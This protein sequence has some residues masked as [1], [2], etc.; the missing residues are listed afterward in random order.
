M[1]AHRNFLPPTL[2]SKDESR[3]PSPS[4]FHLS[5][6]G[7]TTRRI[8]TDTSSGYVAP[9]FEGKEQQMEA[10]IGTIEASGFIPAAFI[11]D[12]VEWFYTKLGIDDMYF[13][14]ESVETIANHILAL[15][16]GKVAAF[17]RA[18]KRLEIRLDRE[19]TDHAV[20]IDTSRPGVS[21]EE[22]PRYETRIDEK[23]LNDSHPGK[24]YRV[25][26]FRSVE[27]L[28]GDSN[29]QLRCYF[30]YQ[31]Q[32]EE[33]QPNENETDIT[34]I[35][36]K[37]F[38]EKASENTKQLYGDIVQAVVERTGPVIEMFEVQ[39]TR[40]KRLIIGYRQRSAKGLFSAMSDLY[41]YYGVTSARKY[42]EQFSN[43]V[44]VMSL[45]LMPTGSG[46]AAKHPPI[47]ASIHQIMK[48]V[49]LLYCI[50]QNNF[51]KH[52]IRGDLSLQETIYAHCVSIFITHFL[53]RL[54]NEYSSL[55]SLLDSNNTAHIEVL[56][57][58]KR[59]LRQETFT[60]EY[61]TEII[62]E[63]P[64]LVRPLYLQ[65]A[66][67]HYVQTRGETDDF[68]PTLS[69]QRLRQD[70]VLK[71]EEIV[72]HIR[73]TV[74]NDHQATVMESFQLFNQHVLK[75]N[76]YTPTKVAL[77]FRFNPAFLPSIEYPQPLYG[78]FLVIGSEF[79]GFHLR[80]RDIA[81]GGIRIVKSRNREAYAINVRSM[82]DENYNL[83]N[84]QQRKNKDIPEGGSKGVVLL[85]YNSQDKATQ[86]FQKYIDSVL[87][88]LL[89]PT[90][91]GIKDPIVDLHG[92]PEILFMGPDENTASLVNWATEHARIRGAPWWKSFFTGKSPRL[93]GI[94]HDEYGMTSLSVREYVLGIYRKLKIDPSLVRKMQTGGPDGDLGSNEILLSNE[95][96]VAIVD[97]SGVLVDPNGLDRDELI[98]LAKKRVMISEF[99]ITKLSKQGYRVLVDESKIKLPSGE[100]V[101]NGTIFRNTFHLKDI[102]VDIFTPCG[103]RPEAIESGNVGQ[104]IDED[105]KSKIPYIVEGANLF[106][107]QDAKIRLEKAGAILFKDAS[108]NK[109]GVTS[110]SLEVLAS[111][112]FDDAGFVENMCVKEDGSR[113]EF[114]G[115]YVKEVQNIIKNNARLEFEAIWA[116]HERT[117][118]PRSLISDD[119][120]YA[121]TNLDEELQKTSL[122]ADV[123]LRKNVLGAALPGLLVKKLGLE[124][125][126]KRVPEGYL[127]AIF[128]SY[129]ASRFV[130]RCGPSASPL[131]FYSFM[132]TLTKNIHENG[133]SALNGI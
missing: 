101:P 113:P 88:L 52:F 57:K 110:S 38:L 127:K 92:K 114:Y 46:P 126:V 29:A 119:L 99:D 56:T 82:F 65:F 20:Y 90:S 100:Y 71:P 87:D 55:L 102:G 40:E 124:T 6:P 42:V 41:H 91:P 70:P 85:D 117:G 112:S 58:I 28:G 32:F 78:M 94:P 47:E 98:R 105:G 128:G 48:E 12:E 77:S 49:S 54:G 50:P 131:A 69:Y 35:A 96:Y 24:A 21:V 80:F 44:T 132:T 86:A 66:N 84:T 83:A 15:Y 60:A 3:H 61:I 68:I 95:K 13:K 72:N 18:D 109:G 31:C 75:T 11:D 108:A 4:P 81:R 43:G 53:N 14:S 111:L 97:G 118:R 122:W 67:T 133:S 64:Q 9:K 33:T 34:K 125:L 73:T 103:G 107:S 7:G 116:E 19:G 37:M 25:E 27:S 22:G 8:I 5:I 59:R 10:V 104:L 121:I 30:V 79:R 1:A 106:I 93:G 130:Y 26:T 62:S 51:Q 36:D 115:E 39:G 120:S 45:Y 63:Y 123:E 23:Y 16:A 2:T 17:S 76:F 74:A 129:L 89:P